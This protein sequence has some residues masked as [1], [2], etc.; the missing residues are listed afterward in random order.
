MAMALQKE[1]TK[2]VLSKIEIYGTLVGL[3]GLICSL[4]IIPFYMDSGEKRRI[5]KKDMN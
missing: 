3:W 5:C 4:C 2:N 1:T